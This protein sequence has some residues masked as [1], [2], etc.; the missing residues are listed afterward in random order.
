MKEGEGSVT[1]LDQSNDSSVTDSF[2]STWGGM[3]SVWGT[4][5]TTDQQVKTTPLTKKSSESTP[6]RNPQ[7]KPS[8]TKPKNPPA[9]K[10]TPTSSLTTPTSAKQATKVTTPLNDDPPTPINPQTVKENT[11][12]TS[13]PI[14]APPTSATPIPTTHSPDTPTHMAPISNDLIDGR[15]GQSLSLTPDPVVKNEAAEISEKER[16]DGDESTNIGFIEISLDRIP[17]GKN[18]PKRE[19]AGSDVYERQGLALPTKDSKPTT[20]TQVPRDESER[21]NVEVPT[22]KEE[23]APRTTVH[24]SPKQL[25]REEEGEGELKLCYVHQQSFV[26]PSKESKSITTDTQSPGERGNMEIELIVPV[27]KE[28]HLIDLPL[29]DSHKQ[30]PIHDECVATGEGGVVTSEGGVVTS[31]GQSNGSD[32]EPMVSSKHHQHIAVLETVSMKISMNTCTLIL[33]H[34]QC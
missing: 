4:K 5:P 32:Q 8:A 3:D 9:N 14:S 12:M 25:R 16:V 1:G 21:D 19:R 29:H 20:D 17:L 15:E 11:N 34:V 31:E 27:S 6:R 18:G 33:V 7:T 26:L 30:L 10:T 2:S 24:D 23:Q 22:S 28:E 13:T